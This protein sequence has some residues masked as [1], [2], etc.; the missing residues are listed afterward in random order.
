MFSIDDDANEPIKSIKLP[1]F[2]TCPEYYEHNVFS[3]GQPK[4]TSNH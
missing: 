2:E 4:I 3:Q 1:D